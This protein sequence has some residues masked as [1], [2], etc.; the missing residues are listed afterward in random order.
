MTEA[1]AVP[2]L[3][4]R[5]R[6]RQVALLLEVQAT[7][8]LRAAAARLGMTQPAATKMLHELENALAIPLFERQGRGL[9]PTAAGRA[10]AEHFHG[11]RGSI[12]ALSRDLQ[13][14]REG[15]GGRL[16]VGHIMASS[17]VLLTRK[18][19]RTTQAWRQR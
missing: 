6:L 18:L 12:A 11:L 5:L 14:L 9:K 15:G 2:Q 13:A 16:A 3:L 4:N 1:H 10:V 7:G 19:D 17:P 8:T